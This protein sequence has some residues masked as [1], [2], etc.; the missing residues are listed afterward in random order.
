MQ[1]SQ[2]TI[3]I[4]NPRTGTG[5]YNPGRVGV[6]VDT[7][8]IHWISGNLADAD[9]V[10]KNPQRVAAAH[11]A[12]ED[13]TVH[14]YVD[15]K[16]TAFQAGN[17][18][19]NQRSVGIEHSAQP[20]RDAS[21]ATY[22]TSSQLIATV[23]CPALGKKVSEMTFKRHGEI[24]ATDCC[25]TVDVGRIRSRA[26]V[27]EAE[28]DAQN[29]DVNVGGATPAETTAAETRFTVRLDY[30]MHIRTAPTTAS[31]VYA[32]YPKG[33]EIECD[34]VVTGQVING[35]FKWYRTALHGE[36]VSAAYCSIIPNQ[37]AT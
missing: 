22:E 3:P 31:A 21:D 26:L 11:Y 12:I 5:N 23:I 37:S 25:G 16:N 8:V 20:G 35:N 14:Q 27:I 36:Y 28:N 29:A 24:V 15:L 10:F 30:P 1:I 33:S 4:Y 32:T 18:P 2:V 7:I 19:V 34:G 17:Y 13:N 9:M 6:A